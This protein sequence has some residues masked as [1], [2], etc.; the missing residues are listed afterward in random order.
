MISGRL[1]IVLV[2]LQLTCGYNKDKKIIK[3]LKEREILQLLK[4]LMFPYK[5]PPNTSWNSLTEQ[6]DED[7][8]RLEKNEL[9]TRESC[10][11][12]YKYVEGEGCVIDVTGGSKTG[13]DG[14]CL[15]GTG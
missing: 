9:Q 13:N 8:H 4:V 10:T 12:G 6:C 3:D 1:V 11:A 5:C 7:T 15:P 2:C 14:C